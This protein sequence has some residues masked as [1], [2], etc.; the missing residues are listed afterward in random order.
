MNPVFE[1]QDVGSNL[2]L[3]DL[4]LL[5]A[6]SKKPWIYLNE[7][8]IELR[9]DGGNQ[10]DNPVCKAARTT[11]VISPENKLILP[12]YHLGVKEFEINNN[13]FQLWHSKDVKRTNKKRRKIRSMSRVY[14]KLLHAAKF[15]YKHQQILVQS[16]TFY[17]QIQLK[18]RELETIDIS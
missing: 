2:S 11:I 1:Y 13:L 7:G 15:C 18:K 4:N 9:K 10:I 3:E 5:S 6:Y 16:I 14:Y 8:F 12:C 17:N